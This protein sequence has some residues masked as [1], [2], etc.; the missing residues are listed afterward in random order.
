MNSKDR[1]SLAREL[2]Q[3]IEELL[4]D[5][6]GLNW[7]ELDEGTLG[8]LRESA[9]VRFEEVIINHLGLEQDQDCG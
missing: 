6:S 2:R 5:R 4:N 8:E 7:N 9:E 1:K 3:T